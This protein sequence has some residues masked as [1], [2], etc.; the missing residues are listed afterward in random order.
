MSFRRLLIHG[1]VHAAKQEKRSRIHVIEEGIKEFRHGD[2][3]DFL[4]DAQ[5]VKKDI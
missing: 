3:N 4:G 2:L 5:S 1:L